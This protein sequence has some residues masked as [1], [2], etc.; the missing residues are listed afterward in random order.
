MQEQI[1]DL[2]KIISRLKSDEFSVKINLAS[3]F[4]TAVAIVYADA[5]VAEAIRLCREN[6]QLVGILLNEIREIC[7]RSVDPR[8]ES[9]WDSLLA[10]LL[11]I[12]KEADLLS[13]EFASSLVQ[14]APQIWWARRLATQMLSVEPR[15]RDTSDIVDMVQLK[16]GTGLQ[17]ECKYFQDTALDSRITSDSIFAPALSWS[18]NDWRISR[19][20]GL[21]NQP[22]IEEMTDCRA[23]IEADN[24]WS[25][26]NTASLLK[27]NA[28][29]VET[30]EWR[31]AA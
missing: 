5:S 10:A 1:N 16:Q 24:Y 19:P 18:N 6:I 14:R 12:V 28:G 26:P 30:S 25:L 9:P 20:I 7:L 4:S 29:N 8:Y 31:L 3:G 21:L 22:T 2:N 15:D 17:T 11:I 27:R 13:V 23:E